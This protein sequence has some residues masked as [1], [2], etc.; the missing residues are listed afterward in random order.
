MMFLAIDIGNSST[1][2]G[3]FKQNEPF[4]MTFGF[5]TASI[6]SG[7]SFRTELLPKLQ[8]LGKLDSIIIASVVPKAS[9][10]LK[11][12]LEGSHE[13]ASIR[14]LK[15][16]DVPIVNNYDDPDQVG[17]DRLLSSLAAYHL[18][19]KDAKKPIILIGFGTATTID[20]INADGQYLGGI[21]ALGIEASA[22]NLH[23][24]AAQ[25]PEIELSF[26]KNILGRTTTQSIQ[27]GIMNGAVAMIEGLVEKLHAENFPEKEILVVATGGLAKLFENKTPFIHQIA[28]HLVL[29]GIAI[30][31]NIS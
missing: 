17:I 16:S 22:K 8:A 2:F 25:L 18:L 21:I 11:E 20:C 29:E 28:P 13:E 23:Q 10:A 24:I 19:G 27:S 6:L 14:L 3:L 7:E 5:P 1:K 31:T 4:E 9:E 12:I 26:P 15:N 30:A